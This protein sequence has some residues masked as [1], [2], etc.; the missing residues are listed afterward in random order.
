[1]AVPVARAALAA[2]ATWLGACSLAE[3]LDL[4]A[5]GLT[6]PVLAWLD[7][8]HTDYTPGVAA[9]IDLTGTG[10]RQLDG[11]GGAAE[12]A[13]RAARVHLKIDPGLARNGCPARDW[14]D[15]VD[16]AA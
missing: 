15:L 1:G 8:V 4:R 16:G 6:A 5:A 2:G 9:G 13:G 10:R 7:P 11:L 12:R 3:A 14:P